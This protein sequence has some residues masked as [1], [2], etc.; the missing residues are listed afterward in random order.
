M[1][2]HSMKGLVVSSTAAELHLGEN[3]RG[4]LRITIKRDVMSGLSQGK[5]K[6]LMIS[7]SNKVF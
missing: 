5:K 6:S 7:E 3:Y 4:F 2:Q 1:K